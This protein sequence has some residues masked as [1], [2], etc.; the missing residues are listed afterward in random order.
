MAQL[1]GVEEREYVA[2]DGHKGEEESDER[3]R[4]CAESRRV[5]NI[6]TDKVDLQQ[7]KRHP[8]ERNHT[9]KAGATT[10][11]EA[12][13]ANLFACACAVEGVRGGRIIVKLRE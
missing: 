3:R 8:C 11:L 7:T 9:P 10:H 13:A 5:L 12:E 4:E 2:H 6:I 1:H